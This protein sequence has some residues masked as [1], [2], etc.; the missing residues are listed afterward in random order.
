M[1][2]FADTAVGHG[3]GD[4][5]GGHG[6]AHMPHV[7]AD[8]SLEVEGGVISFYAGRAD[9]VATCC[10]PFH[11]D[12]SLTRRNTLRAGMRGRPLGLL[13]AFLHSGTD[14]DSKVEHTEK[15]TVEALSGNFAL[16][17]AL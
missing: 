11:H 17:S 9:F 7:P 15:G 14:H 3:G 1:G 2:A 16:R 6:A 12:C 4:G 13:F 8:I 10:H 5:G